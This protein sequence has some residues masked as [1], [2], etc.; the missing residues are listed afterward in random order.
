MAIKIGE[1]KIIAQ[2]VEGL[3]Y[4]LVDSSVEFLL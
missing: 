4:I 1:K 2:I 3:M